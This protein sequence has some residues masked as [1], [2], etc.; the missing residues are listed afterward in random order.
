[1]VEIIERPQAPARRRFDIDAN[2]RMAEAGVPGDPRRI[3]LIDGEIIDM[4]AF[5]SPHAAV[6]PPHTPATSIG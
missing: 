6:G 2:Y 1:M 4:A 3:E 5:G